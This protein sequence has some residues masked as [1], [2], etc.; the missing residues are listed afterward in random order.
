MLVAV[1][2]THQYASSSGRRRTSISAAA[3]GASSDSRSGKLDDQFGHR[4]V[5]QFSSMQYVLW[6]GYSYNPA[7]GDQPAPGHL[8]ACCPSV[9][10]H[11]LGVTRR[12]RS[13]SC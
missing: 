8:L 9:R 2:T 5:R 1:S 3:T 11:L 6:K 4:Q 12:G 7:R 13:S 10:L